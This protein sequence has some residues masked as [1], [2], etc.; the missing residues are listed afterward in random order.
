MD[1]WSL[2]M[3]GLHSVFSG[4]DIRC[5][6]RRGPVHSPTNR[7]RLWTNPVVCRSGMQNRTFNVRHV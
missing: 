4:G 1:L 5:E 7:N 2:D 6:V 3:T